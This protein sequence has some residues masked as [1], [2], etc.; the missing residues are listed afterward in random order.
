[1]TRLS[2]QTASRWFA[3]IPNSFSVSSGSLY[4]HGIPESHIWWYSQEEKPNTQCRPLDEALR[5]RRYR[6]Y[7][8]AESHTSSISPRQESWTVFI[9]MSARYDMMNTNLNGSPLFH[10]TGRFP[11]YFFHNQAPK[12]MSNKYY[13]PPLFVLEV[14]FQFELIGCKVTGLWEF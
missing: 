4:C 5:G 1:M 11:T 3:K 14:S 6:E 9:R 8:L 10:K 12:R 7:F 13:W 2:L